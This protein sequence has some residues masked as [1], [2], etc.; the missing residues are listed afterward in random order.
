MSD[1]NSIDVEKFQKY[2][3]EIV[4]VANSLSGRSIYMEEDVEVFSAVRDFGDGK[5]HVL[6][7][8]AVI[9]NPVDHLYDVLYDVIGPP[10]EALEGLASRIDTLSKLPKKEPAESSVKKN[11]SM[12]N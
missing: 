5:G 11:S 12:L 3:K 1:K 9:R 4:D 2:A 10:M 8:T 6:V 7:S